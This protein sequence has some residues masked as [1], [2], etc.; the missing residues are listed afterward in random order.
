MAA[1]GPAQARFGAGAIADAAANLGVTHLAQ[2]RSQ[3]RP[4]RFQP[5]RTPPP[6]SD[7]VSP[8]R[9]PGSRGALDSCA[10]C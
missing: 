4:R 5:P 2:H 1:L 3:Q 10:F 8:Y 9:Y 6:Q 7:T